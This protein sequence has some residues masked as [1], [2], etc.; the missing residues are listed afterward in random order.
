MNNNKNVSNIASIS[1]RGRRL[2]I[3]SNNDTDSDCEEMFCTVQNRRRIISSD[4]E[5][6]SECVDNKIDITSNE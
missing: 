1:T 3:R 5:E 6:E 4:S 2:L